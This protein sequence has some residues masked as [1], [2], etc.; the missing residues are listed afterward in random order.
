MYTYYNQR[1]PILSVNQVPLDM[2][3]LLP[4]ITVNYTPGS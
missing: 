3:T 1:K 2:A 4:A